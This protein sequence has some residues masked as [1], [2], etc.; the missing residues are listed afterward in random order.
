[1]TAVSAAA[2]LLVSAGDAALGGRAAAKPGSAAANKIVA[3]GL[4][5]RELE[6]FTPPTGAMLTS[7][8]L[9][10]GTRSEAGTV[11]RDVIDYYRVWRAPGNPKN[12]IESYSTHPPAGFT[13]PSY[14]YGR[15]RNGAYWG[16]SLTLRHLPGAVYRQALSLY[17]TPA[18]GGG[19]TLRLDSWA[20]WLIPRP[21]WERVPAGVHAVA[22]SEQPDVTGNKTFPVATVTALRKVRQL[23]AFVDRL[24]TLQPGGGLIGCP[25]GGWPFDLDF[26]R[27]PNAR[28]A[29]R[30]AEDACYEM[31]FARGGRNGP[32]LAE[33][34]E[35][36]GVLWRL[37]ILPRCH[38]RQ[39]R[40]SATRPQTFGSRGADMQV[41][42]N[43]VSGRVCGLSGDPKM[44]L[45]SA[46]GQPLPTHPQILKRVA[47]PLRRS[48][49]CA[50]QPIP[51][52]VTSA[53][54]LQ[55]AT[56]SPARLDAA[57]LLNAHRNPDR[58]SQTS[59]RAV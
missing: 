42:L 11:L 51:L 36:P 57:S 1:V 41:N 15:T 24:Q 9:G 25:A 21:G 56:R 10:V 52:V 2:F 46:A 7:P 48:P 4:A 18:K 6:A 38:S 33:H 32:E 29:A 8:S 59:S 13:A 5:R 3:H 45:F 19:M 14:G 34:V 58:I 23:I 16:V 40:G 39:L 47:R 37:R 20:A 12:A 43:E 31:A 27:A 30:F 53:P 26:L 44:T 17:A 28:P 55:G 49:D 54:L 35:L 50:S 22:V